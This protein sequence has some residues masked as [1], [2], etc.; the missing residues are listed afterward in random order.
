[1]VHVLQRILACAHLAILQVHAI[2]LSAL[3]KTHLIQ[4]FALEMVSVI[5]LILAFA[6]VV[7]LVVY[8]NPS[9][10][11]VLFGV[12]GVCGAHGTCAGPNQCS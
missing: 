1:M 4:Q 10:A 5:W 12:T 6:I 11:L 7:S 9:T 2:L 3:V 8:V